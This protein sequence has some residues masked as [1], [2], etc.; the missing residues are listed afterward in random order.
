M[1]L[2][3][4]YFLGCAATLALLAFAACGGGSSAPKGTGG[5]VGT[6]GR[7]ETGGSHAES[8]DS[9][10]AGGGAPSAGAPS[11]GAGAEG[12]SA[13]SGAAGTGTEGGLGGSSGAG[14]AGAPGAVAGPSCK[15]LEETCGPN[16]D[17]NCCASSV[18]PGG[19][20]LRNNGAS[21]NYSAFISAYRLDVYEV[22]IGRFK[23]FLDGYQDHLPKVGSGNNPG[24]ANDPGW[25]AEW[26]ASLVSYDE[27]V[28][29][30]AACQQTVPAYASGDDDLLP[31]SCITWFE[32]YAFCIW[33]GGRLPTNAEW[34]F[35]S[36]GG[37]EQRVYPWSNPPHSEEID[38]SYAV[39]YQSEDPNAMPRPEDVGS[40]SPKGDARWGQADMSGN[41]WEW[42]QDW[43]TPLP[44]FCIN[45]AALN[46]EQIRTMVG[47][48]YYGDGENLLSASRLYH[49]PKSRDFVLGV[50]CARA[51]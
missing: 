27:M 7:L 4:R 18:V 41:V 14:N 26:D 23:R 37:D 6:G 39:Y 22:T 50:R 29:G 19:S 47:G 35:A 16:A 8:G 44:D 42:N 25:R 30:I 51:R 24:N 21:G 20:F 28:A 3:H 38:P 34:N 43:Y 9:S 40:K 12:G 11:A 49:D 5:K 10:V 13:S 45:C 46:G 48:S 31:M 17:Q 2:G 15:G 33:D 36:A 1:R 32:A